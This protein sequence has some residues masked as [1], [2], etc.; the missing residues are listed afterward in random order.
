VLTESMILAAGGGALGGSAAWVILDG[1]QTTTLN[2][3]TYTQVAF[4]LAVTPGLLAEGVLY[5][6]A[7]GLFGGLLP[8]LHA[9]RVPIAAGLREPEP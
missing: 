7:M 8:A 4:T 6:I 3:Q 1:Y 2:W 5:A 9:A